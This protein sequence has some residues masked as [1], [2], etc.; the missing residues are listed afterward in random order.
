MMFT[1]HDKKPAQG[2]R[3]MGGQQAKAKAEE[4]LIEEEI[5]AA[6]GLEPLD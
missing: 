6:A 1:K 3:P 2:V 5:L 4:I